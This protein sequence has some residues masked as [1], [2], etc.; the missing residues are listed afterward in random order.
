MGAAEEYGKTSGRGG[1][2]EAFGTIVFDVDYCDGYHYGSG[3]DVDV[4]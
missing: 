1:R 4:T 2:N 3:Y